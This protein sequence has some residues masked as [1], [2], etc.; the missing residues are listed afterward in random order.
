MRVIRI[1]PVLAILTATVLVASIFT[2]S[3]VGSVDATHVPGG[4]LKEVTFLVERV[5]IVHTTDLDID[6]EVMTVID[7][8]QP[9]KI[10]LLKLQ[11]G[12]LTAIGI[13]DLDEGFVTQVRLVTTAATITFNGQTFSLSI[14][15]G[16]VKLNGVLT[17]LNDED[18]VFQF[19]VEKS[20][21]NTGQGFKL[22]PIIKFVTTNAD[23]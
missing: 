7:F 13:C 3:V 11:S 5:E 19:D 12:I 4:V 23:C 16:V 1:V 8:P 2:F 22:K 9:T 15:S 17:V 6:G 20:V 18:G 21:I 14:P 10:E